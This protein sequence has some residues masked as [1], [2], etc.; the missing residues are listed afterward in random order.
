MI[1]LPTINQPIAITQHDRLI[2][3]RDDMTPAQ[4]AAY[5]LLL[6]ERPYRLPKNFARWSDL[7]R[8]IA[9]IA[10]STGKYNDR[11]HHRDIWQSWIDSRSPIYC[12]SKELL[13]QFELT[14]LTGVENLLDN[15]TPP[16]ANFILALPDHVFRPGLES[17]SI[18]A[19]AV[20]FTESPR[21]IRWSA[22]DSDFVVHGALGRV[23]TVDDGRGSSINFSGVRRID[24]ISALILQ[25]AL[26]LT[27]LPELIDQDSTEPVSQRKPSRKT[28]ADRWLRPRWI[29]KDFVRPRQSAGASGG[30][31]ASPV[32]HWRR[33]HWRNQAVGEGRKDRSLIWVRPALIASKMTNSPESS[34]DQNP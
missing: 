33:G 10:A 15:W 7:A 21:L 12:I 6:Q 19:I 2:K 9:S 29:G 34:H 14:A 13:R 5:E 28:K 30:H 22:I 31:H 25:A 26:A 3:S 27:Y 16:L 4:I 20:A 8:T 11:P 18:Q 17:S 1:N 32:T 24:Q 23:D